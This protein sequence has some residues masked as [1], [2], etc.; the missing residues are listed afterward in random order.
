M[1]R[2]D[3]D[4]TDASGEPRSLTRIIY[5][6]YREDGQTF[7]GCLEVFQDHS[8]FK[9]LLK[10]VWFESRYRRYDGGPGRAYH[11]L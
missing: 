8:V 4:I 11:F 7:A 1:E 5:P 2:V 6:L 10:R 9:D 3:L